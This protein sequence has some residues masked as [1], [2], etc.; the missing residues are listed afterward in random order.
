MAQAFQG[1][2]GVP[3][4]APDAVEVLENAQRLAAPVERRVE[5][6]VERAVNR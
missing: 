5:D 1:A 4:D 2:R 3:V 6:P